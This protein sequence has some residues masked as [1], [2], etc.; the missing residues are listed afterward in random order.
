MDEGIEALPAAGAPGGPRRWPRCRDKAVI[1]GW[2]GGYV[3]PLGQEDD[4]WGQEAGQA[5][6]QESQLDGVENIGIPESDPE[7]ARQASR[8]LSGGGV[9]APAAT[10]PRPRGAGRAAATPRS[11]GAGRRRHALPTTPLD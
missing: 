4:V 10:S 2:G 9:R 8:P 11:A 1:A 5:R 6:E 3:P 7:L